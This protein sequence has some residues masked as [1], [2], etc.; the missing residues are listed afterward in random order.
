MHGGGGIR[1]LEVGMAEHALTLMNADSRRVVRRTDEFNPCKFEDDPDLRDRAIRLSGDTIKLLK[2]S[3][4]LRR[5]TRF[6]RQGFGRPAQ[7]RTGA[8]NLYASQH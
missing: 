4:G 2:S 1:P 6:F 7:R 3:N 5:E 8:T